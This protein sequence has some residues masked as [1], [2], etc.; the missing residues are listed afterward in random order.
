MGA[1]I[2]SLAWPE[3]RRAPRRLGATLIDLVAIL[4]GVALWGA[5]GFPP[6]GVGASFAAALVASADLILPIAAAA[7]A[8]P[9]IATRKLAAGAILAAAVALL[10]SDLEANGES[11]GV[12]G[13]TTL[14]PLFHAGSFAVLLWP[15]LSPTDRDLRTEVSPSAASAPPFLAAGVIAAAGLLLGVLASPHAVAAP[16]FAAAAAGALC[17]REVLRITDRRR[18][19]EQLSSSLDLET[20]LLDLQGDGDHAFSPLEALGRTCSLASDVLRASA[21][22]AW[23]RDGDLLRLEASGPD[24]SPLANM[25][26]REILIDEPSTWLGR[27][28]RTLHAESGGTEVAGGRLEQVISTILGAGWLLAVPILRQNRAIGVLL[29]VRKP[30]APPFDSFDE[31]KALLIAAQVASVLHRTELHDELEQQLRETTLV[32]RFA[33]QAVGAKSINDVAWYLL[34]SVRSRFDYDRGVVFV[35]DPT[36]RTSLTPVAHFHP[37]SGDG[38]GGNATSESHLSVPL[39]YGDLRVG[40]LEIHRSATSPFTADE[41]RVAQTLAHQAAVAMQ[42]LRLREESGKASA[43]RDL[44]RAKTDLM[45]SVSHDLRGPLANIKG[46]AA[47]LVD[48]GA[49]MPADEQLLYLQTIE[50]EADRLKDLLDHL[51]D[52]S[53][54]E[55]GMLHLA[56]EP[57]SVLRVARAV[58]RSI[59]STSHEFETLIP[60]D[61]FV[62]ADGRRFRQVLQNLTENA[63][64]YSPGG[65]R[66]RLTAQAG[67][68]EIVISV[69]DQGVGVPRHQWDRIFRPYQRADGPST[70]H[71]SGSGLG[72]AIC[73]GIVEAHGGRIWIESEP[74]VGSTFSFTLPRARVETGPLAF[75]GDP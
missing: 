22:L 3:I 60:E 21:A 46:Y 28:F 41:S 16:W 70:V 66:I 56:T 10:L 37:R 30:W 26:G 11:L 71:V 75:V 15:A 19:Q 39:N 59:T 67:E 14:A 47:M 65:G 69:S 17:A 18:A 6:F 48:P 25:I 45:N 42:N 2:G 62:R 8:I 58:V 36:S 20:R 24:Q 35:A 64:K 63:V 50:E 55:A 12:A 74:D 33:V 53:K 29:V 68:S 27:V 23:I 38:M 49:P 9:Q 73:K 43:Y 51:L 44:D 72:L 5:A 13:L 54:I 57:V 40:S 34:E 61:Q 52:L 7:L 32:H 31:Q 4:S 1:S